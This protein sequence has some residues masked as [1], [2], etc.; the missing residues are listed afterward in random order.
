MHSIRSIFPPRRRFVRPLSSIGL[1]AAGIFRPGNSCIFQVFDRFFF[2]CCNIHDEFD[3]FSKKSLLFL[4]LKSK[5]ILKVSSDKFRFQLFFVNFILIYS[6][7][8]L[9]LLQVI[10]TAILYTF[11]RNF[12]QSYFTGNDDLI[13]RLK[14]VRTQHQFELEDFIRFEDSFLTKKSSNSNFSKFFKMNN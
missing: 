10:E 2:C 11:L 6:I 7:V 12:K 14:I 9:Q 4:I 13:K 1:A 5:L 3:I 8:S